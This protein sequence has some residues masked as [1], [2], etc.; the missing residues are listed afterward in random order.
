[1]RAPTPQDLL[2]AWER[3]HALHAVDRALVLLSLTTAQGRDEL[4]TLPLGRRDAQLLALRAVTFGEHLR[5][6]TACPGCGELLELDLR[7]SEL[8]SAPHGAAA[9]PC[10]VETQGYTVQLRPLNSF[11]LAAAA[12]CADVASA[13]R[14]LLAGC[15][16]DARRGAQSIATD[17]LPEALTPVLADGLAHA[18]PQA[19]TVLDLVCPACTQRWQAVFDIAAFLWSEVAAQVRRLLAD[20]HTLARAYGWR[21]ADILAMSAVRRQQYLE[22]VSG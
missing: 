7:C 1:M 15:V 17:E 21:E 13:R 9:E 22:M 16:I 18:D 4:A 6:N 12:R 5:A 8:S 11:D 14:A 2:T 19:D 10:T 3:G 20:V